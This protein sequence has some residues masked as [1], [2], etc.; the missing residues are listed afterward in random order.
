MQNNECRSKKGARLRESIELASDGA[1]DF[2]YGCA[3]TSGI[4][5][6][7]REGGPPVEFEVIM[8]Q[9]EYNQGNKGADEDLEAR[10]FFAANVANCYASKAK[11][12][13]QVGGVDNIPDWKNHKETIGAVCEHILAGHYAGE[14]I[15][16]DSEKEHGIE[17]I[18]LLRPVAEDATY[19]KQ[20]THA[21]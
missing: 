11:E 8:S 4:G 15:C 3:E 16:G 19:R 12:Q 17:L 13:Q 9:G 10:G 1:K 5:Y 6:A 7:D 2:L 20:H 18:Y 14:G 21:N